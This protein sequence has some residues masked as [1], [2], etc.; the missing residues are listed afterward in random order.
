[1][2]KT[3]LITG[4][5]SG[6]G[7]ELARIHAAIGGDLILVARS[8]EKLNELKIDLEAKY[9]IVAA[10]ITKDLTAPNAAQ[11]LYDEEKSL[12]IEVESYK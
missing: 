5:S 1:M 7:L 9:K 4:A 12:D 8:T 10:V 3:A 6:I 11:K 2:K